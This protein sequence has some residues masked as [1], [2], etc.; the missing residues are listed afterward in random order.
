MS[1]DVITKMPSPI[2]KLFLKEKF[3]KFSGLYNNI[4]AYHWP[5]YMSTISEKMEK[6]KTKSKA[7]ESTTLKFDYFFVSSES[8]GVLN[9][10]ETQR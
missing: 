7:V 4:F 8:F 5:F 10:L 2:K 9:G 6:A 1:N 3:D